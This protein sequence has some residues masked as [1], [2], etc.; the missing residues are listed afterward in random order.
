MTNQVD[1]ES[2]SN[3]TAKLVFKRD[4]EL[5]QIQGKLEENRKR[6]LANR[7]LLKKYTKTNPHVS[8]LVK[9]YDEYYNN[10]KT[11]IK[12]QIRA[13]EKIATHLN[14]I[15]KDEEKSM[16]F[17]N[18]IYQLK[19]DKTSVTKEIEFLKKML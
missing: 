12:M 15:I 11:N 1:S 2:E 6:M 4:E 17:T 16:N 19:K 7:L 13:L 3:S 14:E 10:F 8:G 5:T 18:H 9:V